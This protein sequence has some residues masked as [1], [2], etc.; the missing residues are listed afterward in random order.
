MFVAR[1]RRV[2]YPSSALRCASTGSDGLWA[3][4]GMGHR[5][6]H[7]IG[8]QDRRVVSVTQRQHGVTAGSRDKAV[9]HVASPV[10]GLCQDPLTPS[11]WPF[12]SCQPFTAVAL[13]TLHSCHA[14]NPSQFSRCQPFTA[15]ICSQLST[16]FLVM[17]NGNGRRQ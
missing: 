2:P 1:A 4:R 10:R 8:V 15:V 7:R 3:A 9:R 14:V 16:L 12:H 11:K 13:S 6:R 17:N 5:G